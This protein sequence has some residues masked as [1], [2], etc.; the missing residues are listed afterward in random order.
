[1]L[2]EWI[3]FEITI[4]AKLCSP[5]NILEDCLFCIYLV[6]TSQLIM[7]LDSGVHF[8]LHSKFDSK[9]Y[10]HPPYERHAWNYKYTN[11]SQIKNA[12][13]SFKWEQPV[14][15][16]SINKKNYFLHQAIIN[17]ISNCIQVVHDQNPPW[18]N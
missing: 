16:S 13:A 3:N 18:M 11:A 14:P 9:F 2:H 12:L 15:N 4:D 1:M 5:T 7:V 17:V 10:Y 8:S 6:F